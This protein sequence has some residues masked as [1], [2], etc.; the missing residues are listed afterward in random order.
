MEKSTGEEKHG[1]KWSGQDTPKVVEL[2][3]QKSPESFR[4]K[5]PKKNTLSKK[6]RGERERKWLMPMFKLILGGGEH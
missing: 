2:G 6:K 3:I 1:K 5:A 4:K